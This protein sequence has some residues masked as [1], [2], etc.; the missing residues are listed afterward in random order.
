[1]AIYHDRY[2]KFRDNGEIKPLPGIY[3]PAAQTD[4]FL[5]YRQ[6]LT[7]LDK[8]SDDYYLTPFNGWLI[9]SANPE[10]GGLEFLIPDQT[11]IR[12]PYPLDSGLSRYVTEITKHKLLYG[13]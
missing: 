7:R 8:V 3:I 2:A 10:F 11:S 1:M 13:E 4:K 12:I 9:M 5:V 6:G